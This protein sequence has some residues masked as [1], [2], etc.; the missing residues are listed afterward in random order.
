MFLYSRARFEEI[1]RSV[2]D[3]ALDLGASGASVDVSEGSGLS[4]NVHRG[5]VSTIEQMGDKGLGVTL[6]V[7]QRRGSAMTSDFSGNAIA[8]AVR[9][10]FDIARFTGE[11]ECAGLPDPHMLEHAPRDLDLFHPWLIEPPEAVALACEMEAAAFATS[12]RIANT[13]GVSVSVRHG[14]AIH[15]NSLGFMGGYP[16]SWHSLSCS[17]I[18]KHGQSMQID[19]WSSGARS[20]D[21]LARPDV[22]GRYA[23]ERALSRLGARKVASCKVPVLFEAPL[24]LGFLSHFVQA[25]S[26]GA[27]YRKTSFLVDALGTEVFAPHIDIDEDPHRPG[28]LGSAPFDDEGVATHARRLVDAGHLK[29]WFLSTYSARKLGLT[30]TGNAGGAHALRLSSR[31]TAPQDDLVA[32]LLSLIHI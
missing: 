16:F 20:A 4:V 15:A 19:G 10:A 23:A 7:G 14:H 21:R 25:A 2:L 13:D 22:L 12:P 29:G 26:G 5:K 9:A 11:D 27:L 31:L 32:M 28:E 30:T 6:F 17:P 1:A 18:A 3:Q 24:A 8:D